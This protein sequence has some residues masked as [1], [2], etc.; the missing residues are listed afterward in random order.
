MASFMVG[1]Q[2]LVLVL[3]DSAASFSSHHDLV[4]GPVE[5]PRSNPGFALP[6]SMDC[7]LVDQVFQIRARETGS[8]PRK[9]GEVDIRTDLHVLHVVSQDINPSANV[10]QVN[11]NPAVESTGSGQSLVQRLR[12]VG[13]TDDDHATS[14]RKPIELSK[15]LVQGL[16]HVG[17][18]PFV[19]LA[20]YGIQFIDEDDGRGLVSGLREEFPH[21]FGSHTDV[22]F[23]E[24]R[25][26]HVEEWHTS[27]TSHST[28]EQCLSCSR[29][30]N[31]KNTLGQFATK[32][33]KSFRVQQEFHE[34]LEFILGFIASMHVA[35]S[36]ILLLGLGFVALGALDVLQNPGSFDKNGDQDKRHVGEKTKVEQKLNPSENSATKRLF[37][38]NV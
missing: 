34:F 20:T 10:W 26:G 9:H 18:I 13:C 31:E 17:R 3:D 38:D 22:Y 21:T 35:K 30:S 14:L 11:N 2:K 28:S 5:I 4:L 23:I 25:T 27:F 15:Q 12:I 1:G 37:H 32:R 29:G 36:D 16:F 8:T 7:G 33:I 19:S 24:F 6:T